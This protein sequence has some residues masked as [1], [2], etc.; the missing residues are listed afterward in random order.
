[1]SEMIEVENVNTPGKTNRVNAAKYADMFAAFEKALPKSSPGLTQSEM[2]DQVKPHL[3]D[4]LFPGGKTSGW[5]AKTVQ[6]DLEA[7]G[8][9]VREATKPLRWHWK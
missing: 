4:D 6:L 2:I 5:W 8:K 1:M 3:S 9:L 7:K